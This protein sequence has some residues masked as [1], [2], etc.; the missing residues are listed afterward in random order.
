MPRYKLTIEYDGAPFMGWQ[1]QDHGPSVQGVIEAA[2]AKLNGEPVE[3]YGAGRTDSGVHALAQVAHVDLV[4]D[5]RSDKVR[6]ALNFHIA[7]QPVSILS[8][9]S[10]S[11]D[12]HARFDAIER[13]YL[14]RLIDRRPK[15]ALDKGRVWRIPQKLD[16]DLMHQAAQVFIGEHDFTTFRDMQCQAKSPIKT[17]DHIAIRR[18]GEEIHVDLK[19]RSFLHKQVRSL[20]GTLAEVGRGQWGIRDVTRALEAKDRTACGPVAPAEGLYLTQVKY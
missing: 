4:K 19:A 3:V 20:V 5:L 9:E 12:F 17:L 13:S 15:L 18:A 14:Y 8:A 1:W 2:V 6:D 10:V 16:A 7:D 11:D